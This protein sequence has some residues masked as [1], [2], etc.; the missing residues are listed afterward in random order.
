MT[1]NMHHGRGTDKK[2][3][4]E[5]IAEVIQESQA[6]LIGLNEVDRHFSKRSNYMNQVSWLA[7]HLKMNQAFGETVTLQA[8]GSTVV[9]QYGNAFLSRYPIALEKNHS[10]TV[11]SGITEGRSLLEIQVQ[12]DKQ[13][14]KV[15][16]THLSLNPFIHKKQTDF[17]VEKTRG[18]SHPIVIMGDWNMRPGAKAW[19]RMTRYFADVGEV[20]GK[21][22]C[23]TFPSFR[24]KLQLDYIFVSHDIHISS[25]EVIKKIP[26]ASDHLPL[27][28][29]LLLTQKNKMLRME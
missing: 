28:A 5:R 12:L 13:L 19:K 25:V 7:K 1:F 18:S 29:T 2:L 4:L 14:L 16:V 23:Y 21:G 15:Y 27:K 24:P 20:V 26:A 22:V 11:G 3:S 10:F 17:I 8:K 9:R 6:D